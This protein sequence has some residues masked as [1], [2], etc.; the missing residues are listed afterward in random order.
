MTGDCLA[1]LRITRLPF[2]QVM[3]DGDGD[4]H[5]VIGDI[6]RTTKV[7]EITKMKD[8]DQCRSDPFQTSS[9]PPSAA[10]FH[11]SRSDGTLKVKRAIT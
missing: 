1:T 7:Y 11:G 3:Q 10:T 4:K 5:Q 8:F 9:N 6:C 2:Y